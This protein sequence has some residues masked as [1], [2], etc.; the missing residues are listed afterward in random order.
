MNRRRAFALFGLVISLGCQ[1]ELISSSADQSQQRAVELAKAIERPLNLDAPSQCAVCHATVAAEWSESMHSQAH[2]EYDSIYAAMRRFRLA[3]G[4]DIEGKCETCHSPRGAKGPVAK[5][6]VSCAACH[7]IEAVHT[8]D[9]ALGNKLIEYDPGDTMRSAR[10]VESSR[11]PVHGTGAA[12]PALA[13]GTTLCLACH[14]NHNNPAG[15]PVCT[16]GSELEA[17]S[18]RGT[19]ASCHMPEVEGPSGAVSNRATHRSHKFLGPHR[20]YLQDDPSQLAA[21]VTM[22]LSRSGSKATVELANQSGHGFPS[23]FPGRIVVLRLEGRN[24]D[25]HIVWRNFKSIPT[26]ESPQSVLHK[27]YLDADGTPTLPPMATKLG[28]DSR[29]KPDETRTIQFDVPIRVKTLDASLHYS[30][31]PAAAAKAIGVTDTALIRSVE[32]MRVR[33]VEHQPGTR[34]GHDLS[35]SAECCRHDVAHARRSLV[36]DAGQ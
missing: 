21:A 23:G 3:K 26:K 16:T 15:V 28:R 35:R 33:S 13:D 25:G 36:V 19:C 27:I 6:G 2:Q 29:L 12:H 32:F 20:A 17:S 5:T 31:L 24:A 11:S 14:A 1:N 8:S 9:L 7:N 18:T 22:T 30:L 4:H 10:N 34:L